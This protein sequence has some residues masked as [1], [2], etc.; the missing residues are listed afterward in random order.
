[1]KA[2]W[3]NTSRPIEYKTWVID[4]REVTQNNLKFLKGYDISGRLVMDHETFTAANGSNYRYGS[5]GQ[6]EFETT[7]KEQESVLQLL[8]GKKLI[9]KFVEVVL[10]NSM[11]VCTLER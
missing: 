10:P 9:L 7:C 11:S 6:A 5:V 2:Y 4:S 1:M 8:Y 3:N